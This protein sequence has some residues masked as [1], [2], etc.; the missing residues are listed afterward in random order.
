MN[1]VQAFGREGWRIESDFD[2]DLNEFT[3]WNLEANL[4]DQFAVFSFS[5]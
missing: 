4:S 3:F 2:L 5:F 1:N